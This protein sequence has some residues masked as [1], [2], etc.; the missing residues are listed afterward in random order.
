M[1]S[2]IKTFKPNSYHFVGNSSIM[3]SVI[4]VCSGL[5]QANSFQDEL[6]ELLHRLGE[7][8]AMLLTQKPVG[9]LPD[10]AKEQLSRFMV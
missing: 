1:N 3:S 2:R 4:F 7:I 9:G 6:H 8:D 5:L 10:T